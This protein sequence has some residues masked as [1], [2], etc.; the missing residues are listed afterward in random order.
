MGFK[1]NIC[2]IFEKY[3]WIIKIDCIFAIPSAKGL[4]GSVAGGKIKRIKSSLK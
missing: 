4:K 2:D 1:D 3:F